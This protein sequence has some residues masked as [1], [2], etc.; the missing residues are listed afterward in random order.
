MKERLKR[1]KSSSAV[2]LKRDVPRMA[3]AEN[4]QRRKEGA[5]I[6]NGAACEHDGGTWIGQDEDFG[7]ARKGAEST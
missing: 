3:T 5:V 6:A 1:P 2:S 7:T 4:R